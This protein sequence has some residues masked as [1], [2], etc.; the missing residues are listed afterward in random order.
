LTITLA[1]VKSISPNNRDK[2]IVITYDTASYK[3]RS[4]Q[5]LIG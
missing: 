1:F 2:L 4:A 5:Q 3:S